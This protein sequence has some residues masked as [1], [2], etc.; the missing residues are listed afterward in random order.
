MNG[1]MT[2]RRRPVIRATNDHP[3][4]AASD[5]SYPKMI[6]QFVL[7]K[8]NEF[9]NWNDEIYSKFQRIKWKYWQSVHNKTYN[10][11]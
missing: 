8:T 2:A 1:Q 3:M 11:F 6:V 4:G 5:R 10:Y 9:S 7:K